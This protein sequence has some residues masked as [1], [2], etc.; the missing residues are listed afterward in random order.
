MEKHDEMLKTI[1][2]I[3]TKYSNDSLKS[4]KTRDA[5]MFRA[6]KNVL[7]EIQIQQKIHTQTQGGAIK[8]VFDKLH[9]NDKIFI[10]KLFTKAKSFTPQ[11]LIINDSDKPMNLNDEYVKITGNQLPTIQVPIA[12]A[13]EAKAETPKHIDPEETSTKQTIQNNYVDMVNRIKNNTPKKMKRI[14]KVKE[15]EHLLPKTTLLSFTDDPNEDKKINIRIQ[16]QIDMRKNMQENDK[17]ANTAIGGK[18][19]EEHMKEMNK[20]SGNLQGTPA[21]VHETVLDKTM[22]FN[23]IKPRDTK[24]HQNMGD[25]R[26]NYFKELTER[27]KKGLIQ[28]IK[29]FQHKT[30]SMS[31]YRKFRNEFVN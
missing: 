31:E 4:D 15:I 9:I 21:T 26:A 30:F 13:T 12:V 6:L 24:F 25:I 3:T 5:N 8:I 2:R 17:D 16:S 20:K 1:E 22:K 27:R 14:E 28:P 7:N 11:G 23:R 18:T 19:T 29:E 10:A